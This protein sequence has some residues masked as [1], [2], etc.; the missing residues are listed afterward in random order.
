VQ[1]QHR[2]N[3]SAWLLWTVGFL[4]FPIG[5][6]LAT[7]AVGRVDDA[8]SALIGAGAGGAVTFMALSGLL[9]DRL[10]AATS[11]PSTPIQPVPPAPAQVLAR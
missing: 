7:Q 2:F 6:W 5:G 9:L 10:R 3:V 4:A 1:T 11:S 8:G